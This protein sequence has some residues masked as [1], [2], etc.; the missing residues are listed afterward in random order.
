M[1]RR[2]I[3]VAIAALCLLGAALYLGRSAFSPSEN[4][5]RT[6]HAE[7]ANTNDR[8]EE[9]RV[10]APHASDLAIAG[11]STASR[12]PPGQPTDRDINSSAQGREPF[13]PD[14]ALAA[15]SP[16]MAQLSYVDAVRQYGLRSV[17]ASRS[18]ERFVL[19]FGLRRSVSGAG[20][21]ILATQNR[22]VLS[23]QEL[24]LFRLQPVQPTVEMKVHTATMERWRSRSKPE[25]LGDIA[26]QSI[27]VPGAEGTEVTAW[28]GI[29]DPKVLHGQPGTIRVHASITLDGREF[30][31]TFQFIF[32]GDAPADLTGIT[33]HRSDSAGVT[34]N[35]GI[36][37]RE[38]GNYALEA[39][40]WNDAGEAVA[41]VK[42]ATPLDTG[43]QTTPLVIAPAFVRDGMPPGRYRV[44][45]IECGR[46]LIGG[47]LSIEAL[48]PWRGSYWFVV[49]ANDGLIPSK[50]TDPRVRAPKPRIEPIIR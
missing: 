21:Q 27:T 12:K 44:T 28:S 36:N 5:T 46:E 8:S 23:N 15:L 20:N 17:P 19:D 35:A 43:P 10:D 30:T 50:T 13:A 45:D 39:R 40:I 26:L 47:A 41:L 22:A 1:G 7:N 9:S 11:G 14:I 25:A 42:A 33:S 34:L 2:A 32:S 37:V 4:E 49:E 16:A 3:S 48:V 24:G 18:P 31:E 29:V 6:G 38:R